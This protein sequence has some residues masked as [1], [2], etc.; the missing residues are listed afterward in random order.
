MINV[1][2]MVD[3]VQL[4]WY[5]EGELRNKV[6]PKVM[7]FG[8]AYAKNDIVKR[9]IYSGCDFGVRQ[10]A[11]TKI[12]PPVP[13]PYPVYDYYDYGTAT[14]LLH[15]DNINPEEPRAVFFDIETTSL[16][17]DKG[18]VTSICWMD[19]FTGKMFRSLNEGEEGDERRCLLGF[20][21]Y[22]KQH[23]ILSI[24]GFNSN[25]FDI[26]YIEARCLA[27]SVTFDAR[28]FI[29]QDVMVIANKLFYF[30]SLDVIAENLGVERKLE[31]DNPV[32]LWN[33]GRYEELLKYNVQDVKVTKQIYEKLNMKEFLEALW[34]LTWLDYDRVGANSHISNMFYNKRMWEDG[35]CV[36]Q[37]DNDY[38]GDFGGGA[39]YD[40]N[41]GKF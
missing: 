8:D 38:K 41:T 26:P 33:E 17:P 23:D 16:E 37:V 5:E 28:K 29:K 24:I 10:Q 1:Y 22:L 32:K 15:F 6:V 14:K 21:R 2:T 25:K 3:K 34:H 11:P 39:N 27:N 35:Y 31:V 36:S 9:D 7:L 19:S 40:P 4:S 13:I 30:G 18:V 20:I 12:L